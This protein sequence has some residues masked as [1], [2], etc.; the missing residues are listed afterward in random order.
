MNTT[1]LK[2][3]NSYE[4]VSHTSRETKDPRE[5][6]GLLFQGLTDRIASARAA[7]ANGDRNLR[8]QNISKAQKILFGLLDSLDFDQGGEVA[9]NLA[10]VY[11]YSIRKLTEAH[12]EESDE[13]MR[14]IMD[15]AAGLRDA[16]K[17]MPASKSLAAVQ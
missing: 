13:S 16:W 15:I 17:Q 10:K 8:G 9:Q 7:H 14:E 11:N 4:Q 3:L 5:L 2:A 6:V 1:V 12:A